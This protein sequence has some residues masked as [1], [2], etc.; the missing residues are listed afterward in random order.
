MAHGEDDSVESVYGQGGA[1]IDS[2]PTQRS[3]MFVTNI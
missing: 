2:P 3:A 1:G